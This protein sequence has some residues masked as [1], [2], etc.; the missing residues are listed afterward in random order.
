M[1]KRINGRQSSNYLTRKSSHLIPL[2]LILL[3]IQLAHCPEAQAR[4]RRTFAQAPPQQQSAGARPAQE[5]T[6]LELGRAVERELAGEQKH[7]YQITLAEG[8]TRA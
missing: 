3:W 1:F 8:S 6:T 5:V 2:L 7:E 4:G